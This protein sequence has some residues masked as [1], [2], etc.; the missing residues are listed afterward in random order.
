MALLCYLAVRGQAVPREEL[1]ELL[2]PP[3]ASANL[4][5]ELHRLRHL[6]GADAW[7]ESGS[8][9]AVQAFTDLSAFEQ[10][11]QQEHYQEA[12]TLHPPSE[13]LLRGLEP[14]N[15]PDFADWLELERQRV[16]ALLHHALR[17]RSLE[18]EQTGA[19]AEAL[20]LLRQLLERDPFDENACRAA[21][22]CEYQR[23]NVEA[24]L[25]YFHSCRRALKE[26]LDIEPLAETL[27]LAQE[28]ERGQALPEFHLA[29]PRRRIPKQLLR[30]PTL[31]GRE[32]EWARLEAA[33]QAGQSINISGP[34]GVGK[35]RLLMDFVRSKGE[36]FILEG[37]PGDRVVPYST[38]ARALRE[39]LER[40]P[41]L[42]TRLDPWIG[43][44]LAR[45][46][47]DLIT[48]ASQPA[49]GGETRLFEAVVQMMEL[50]RQQTSAIVVDDLQYLDARSFEVGMG[51]Q[52]R[53]LRKQVTPSEARLVAAFR[54]GELPEAF[55]QG[56]ALAVNFG[57]AVHIELEPL[58]EAAIV[59]LLKSLEVAHA[60]ALAPRLQQLTGGNPQFV[61]ETLKRLYEAGEVHDL[62][63]EHI[64]LPDQVATL[65]TKRLDSL[66]SLACRLALAVAL[67]EPPVD[68]NLLAR[69]LDTSPFNILEALAELERAQ[70]FKQGSFVHDL[71]L[72]T[73]LHYAPR[74]TI[75]LLQR[76][77]AEALEDSSADPVRVAHHWLEAGEL[78]RA[79]TQ[80]L[81]AARRYQAVGLQLDA[82][83]LLG[84]VLTRAQDA[85]T[86]QE[87][88]VGLASSYLELGRY[89]DARGAL[90]PLL[91]E[92][93]SP[94]LSARVHELMAFVH[95]GEGQLHE[96]KALAAKGFEKGAAVGDEPLKQRLRF[97]QAR[98]AHRLECHQEALALL[99]PLLNEL[100]QAPP[101]MLLAA[102]KSEVGALYDELGRSEEALPLHYQ[103]LELAHQLQA[104]HHQ[105]LAS[106]H[107]ICCLLE[108]GRPQEALGPGEAAL[109]LGSY[110]DSDLLRINLARAYLALER[111][112]EA[113]RHYQH[114][115]EQSANPAIRAA[116][117]ARLA[118]LYQRT[119]RQEKIVQALEQALSALAHTDYPRARARVAIA[120]LRYGSDAQRQRLS[121]F[122]KALEGCP[123]PGYLKDELEPLLEHL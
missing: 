115:G 19:F 79:L 96:A 36:A 13:V 84:A 20:T 101:A 58:T 113:E 35:T 43:S 57:M 8:T 90:S 87:A 63:P 23:G 40:Y 17:E 121:P 39:A 85:R 77:I 24:A 6:P 72:E 66:S 46:L 74:E 34:A 47:P 116:A 111:L 21:M 61:V 91:E 5:P 73:V 53:L 92:A 69:I 82:L 105:V 29:P 118:E 108:L 81:A 1:A 103:A 16:S 62:R 48:T 119:N 22:R 32:R 80:Q 86:R 99:E 42:H 7:L 14:K 95:L 11:V 37:R 26:E 98:V 18:L 93:L 88:R 52:A 114:L 27:E 71:L 109:A 50:L 38:L 45:I 89:Q 68:P 49:E 9:V 110:R 120:V 15:A 56:L 78:E 41:E 31:V 94:L 97:L 70:V 104:R 112:D 28:I 122:V 33:W 55:S 51:A 65:I 59:A 3:E 4:R 60:E 83:E 64:E 2:W 10:A 25:G 76:R 30:P 75:T 117:W 100:S 107:L 106:N 67:F 12:L 123:L 44:E 54:R 102:V